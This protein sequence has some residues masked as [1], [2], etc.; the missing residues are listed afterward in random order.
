MVVLTSHAIVICNHLLNPKLTD[1]PVIAP[2]PRIPTFSEFNLSNT[3]DL[4]SILQLGTGHRRPLDCIKMDE[5]DVLR[6]E[7]H[8]RELGSQAWLTANRSPLTAH[9]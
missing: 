5:N 6:L 3:I 8:Q 7:M 9:R 4:D 1:Q 2:M